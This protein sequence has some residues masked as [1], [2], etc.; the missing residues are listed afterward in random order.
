MVKVSLINQKKVQGY[1]LFHENNNKQEIII[2]F[3]GS[4]GSCQ[5]ELSYQLASFG[6]RVLALYYFGEYGLPQTLDTISIDFFEEVLEYIG[7]SEAQDLTLVATSRGTEL[8][9]LLAAH[10]PEIKNLVLFAPASYYFSG[11]NQ[12]HAWLVGEKAIPSIEFSPR[13]QLKFESNQYDSLAEAFMEELKSRE[14][15]ASYETAIHHFTGNLLLF[16]GEEDHVWPSLIMA[17]QIE[18]RA[19]KAKSIQGYAYPNAGHSF[20]FF[21]EGGTKTGNGFAYLDSLEKLHDSLKRWYD[22]IE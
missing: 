7:I 6:Y 9:Q 11:M 8:S 17:Q 22:Q 15:L 14:N 18:Q 1:D 10:Y 20:S 5:L 21:D 3:G 12:E 4:E 2:V 13:V 16:S 19:I